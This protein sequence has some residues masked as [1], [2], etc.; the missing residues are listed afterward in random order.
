[1]T[2]VLLVDDHPLFLDGLRAA[3]AGA[4]DFEVVGEAHDVAGALA[5]AERLAPDLVLMDL[6][7]PDGSGIDATRTLLRSRPELLVLVITMSADDDAVVAAMQAGARGFV[8]KGSGRA[9]L[10]GAVRAVA[11][12]GAVFS[13]AVADRLADWFSGRG[14]APVPTAFGR[15]SA[16]E[17]E[18]LELMARGYDNRRI[19][20]ELV[21]SDKTVRNHVSNVLTKLDAEDRTDAVLRAR[22]AGLG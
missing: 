11:A 13:P 6:N 5:E 4:D 10:L 1:M 12:R 16:R 7:L 14:P 3:L 22:A 15:L 20:R 19:A 8:V 9:E 18:V 17:L 2:R 21:L